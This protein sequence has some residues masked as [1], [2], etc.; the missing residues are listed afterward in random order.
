VS[1][2]FLARFVTL[3]I[4]RRAAL[5]VVGP[6]DRGSS[7]SSCRQHVNPGFASD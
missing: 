6:R 3:L 4:V 2:R 7:P 1:V 5:A